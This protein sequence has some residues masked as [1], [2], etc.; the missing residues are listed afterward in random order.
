[1]ADIL[2]VDALDCRIVSYDWIFAREH[3]ADIDAHWQKLKAANPALYDGRVFLI[4]NWAIDDTRQGRVLRSSHFE[5]SFSSFIAWRDFGFPDPAIANCFAAAALCA[6]DNGYVLG[7]M[8]T[9]TANAGKIYFPAGTPDPSDDAGGYLDLEASVLRELAE[10]TGLAPPDVILQPGW[11]LV[12]DGPRLACL[13]PISCREPAAEMA[14]R[15]GAFLARDARPEFARI[16]CVH[17]RS[18]LAPAMPDYI[19]RFLSD[20][21]P[22]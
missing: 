16:H 12:D 22:G 19:Q 5:T 10:E 4:N 14:Q 18:Q 9:H 11:T 8:N 1:M 21:L 3:R 13:K 2:H 17:T 7:E 20:R 15:I 6:I